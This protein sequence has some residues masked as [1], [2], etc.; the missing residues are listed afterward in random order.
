MVTT[1]P[2]KSIRFKKKKRFH[3]TLL[4]MYHILMFIKSIMS[5]VPFLSPYLIHFLPYAMK[6]RG[7]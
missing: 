6:L 1:I 4:V 2:T 7:V 3:Y 5:G